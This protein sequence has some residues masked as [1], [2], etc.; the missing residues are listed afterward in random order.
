M[1]VCYG[2]LPLEWTGS[3]FIDGSQV[4]TFDMT[5]TPTGNE[6][7]Y[8]VSS[9]WGANFV[10]EATGNPAFDGQ[11]IYDGVMTLNPDNTL[12]IVG[13]GDPA[14]FPGTVP[15]GEATNGNLFDPCNNQ[16]F[17]TLDQGVFQ[18]DFVVDV[19]LSPAP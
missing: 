4:N 8:E 5:L 16:M 12:S 10:A 1:E 11:F 9:A 18:G 15:A 6:G 14:T 13:N 7:E 19:V 3:S 2:V 17:Y